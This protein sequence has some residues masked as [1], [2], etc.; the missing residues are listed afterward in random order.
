MKIGDREFSKQDIFKRVG[1]LG[2]LGGIRRYTLAEGFE[3]GSEIIEVNTGAGLR[4]W[5]S[6]S[7]CLDIVGAEFCGTALTW[8]NVNGVV[9]PA[10]NKAEDYAWLN[11]SSSG[12]V[13][14]CG[15]SNVGAVSEDQGV[16]YQLHG[17][18]HNIPAREV[19]AVSEWVDDECYI[20]ISGIVEEHKM[21]GHYIA[22]KRKITTRMGSNEVKVEDTVENMGA[23]EVPFMLLY[24]CNFGFP[25]LGEKTEIKLPARVSTPREPGLEPA[26]ALW[27]E[28]QVGFA[29]QVYLNSDFEAVDNMVTAKIY[30]PEFPLGAACTG[31]ELDMSWDIS[32]LPELTEWYMP[33]C[34]THSLG[35]E[36]CNC[37]VLGRA[38]A[39]KEGKFKMLKPGEVEEFMLKFAVVQR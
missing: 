13:V 36:P 5:V 22:L 27:R 19:S 21:F 34:G 25:L 17:E 26:P 12:L 3:A 24:H 18:A 14:T 28:P 11:S 10:F 15:F 29:E 1:R 9:H 20:T 33:G 32:T 39:L 37:S 31:L 38:V 8:H 4:F 35:I 2:Q 6:P 30:N 7:K 23:E 16:R